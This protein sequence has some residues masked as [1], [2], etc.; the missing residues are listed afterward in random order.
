MTSETAAVLLSISAGDLYHK[1]NCLPAIPLR[2]CRYFPGGEKL[3]RRDRL[4]LVSCALVKTGRL[5]HTHKQSTESQPRVHDDFGPD[6]GVATITRLLRSSAFS[7]S[8]DDFWTDVQSAPLVFDIFSLGLYFT[9]CNI[10]TLP[11]RSALR[12]LKSTY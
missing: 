6:V 9:R 4:E 10:V 3:W 11:A 8:A 5:S 1:K 12:R 7:S 2:R